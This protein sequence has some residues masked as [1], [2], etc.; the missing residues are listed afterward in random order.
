MAYTPLD[1]PPQAFLIQVIKHDHRRLATEFKRYF[2]NITGALAH[3]SREGI[4]TKKPIKNGNTSHQEKESL[5][6]W[7]PC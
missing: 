3:N 5:K 6:T 4:R 1:S 7:H 2:P